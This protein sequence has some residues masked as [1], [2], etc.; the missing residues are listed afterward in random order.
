MCEVYH[1]TCDYAYAAAVAFWRCVVKTNYMEMTATWGQVIFFAL[2]GSLFSLVGG[3]YMLLGGK[4]AGLLQRIALPFAAGALLAASFFDLLPEAL[5]TGD[6]HLVLGWTLGGFL[7]F[8]VAERGLR[9]FHH[10]HV[11]VG[12]EDQANRLLI[13]FG[14]TLHNFLDGLALGASFLVSP[15]TGIITTLA[16]AAHEIPQEIGDFGLLL[17]KGL[18]KVSVLVVNVI[19]A[20]ATLV[21]AALVFGFGDTV[22]LPVEVLLA[23]TAGFFIY[24]AA[25]DIIPSIHKKGHTRGANWETIIL[26]CSAAI[27]ACTTMLIHSL[28][29]V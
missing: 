14:D 7:F 28:L 24:I 15:A 16:V 11:H 23:I 10:H 29:K 1:I 4:G 18:S 8:F 21:G 22:R 26:I 3:I 27:V 20:L 17:K 6:T 12:S 9:W 19:S 2:V 5:E 13:I 25:A